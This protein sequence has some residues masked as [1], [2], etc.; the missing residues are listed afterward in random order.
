MLIYSMAFSVVVFTADIPSKALEI[1][2]ILVCFSLVLGEADK[3]VT[4]HFT[5]KCKQAMIDFQK[6]TTLVSL[7]V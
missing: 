6:N 5:S 7:P 3:N 4:C 2:A 1:E